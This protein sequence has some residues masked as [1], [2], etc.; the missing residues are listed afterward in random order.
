MS[1]WN[2]TTPSHSV[3]SDS[4]SS[5][6]GDL[7]R[8]S[9]RWSPLVVFLRHQ[10]SFHSPLRD[11][12]QLCLLGKFFSMISVLFT[13]TSSSHFT[14][15]SSEERSLS[16]FTYKYVN[17]LYKV[18]APLEPY[19]KTYPL[20][21]ALDTHSPF[22]SEKFFYPLPVRYDRVC[23][24]NYTVFKHLNKILTKIKSYFTPY[25]NILSYS[26]KIFNHNNYTV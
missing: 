24:P 13:V 6:S 1:G 20:Y 23:I 8:V 10:S 17:S 9:D 7:G 25:S 26:L 19:Y 2:Y 11:F 14:S 5:I 3:S 21:P 12:C 18:S 16:L 15:V 4:W 22:P